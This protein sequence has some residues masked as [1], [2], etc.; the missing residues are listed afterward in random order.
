MPRNLDIALLRAFV[1]VAEA[2]GMTRAATLLNLTQG[3]VSQQVKRLEG[4]FDTTLFERD[5]AGLRLTPRGE[6]LLPQARR[7]LEANDALWTQMT[8]PEVE[9]EVRVGVPHDIVTPYMPPILRAFDREWPRVQV[10]IIADTSP[11]LLEKLAAG[12]IDLTLTTERRP[13]EEAEVLAVEPLVW[14]G[15]PG[16]LAHAR[17]PLPL[18]LGDE[19]C[20]FRRSVLEALADAGLD[21]RM[22]CAMH[23]METLIAIAAADLG[24]TPLLRVAVPP[25]LA[26]L[27]EDCGLPPLPPFAIALYAPRGRG[28]P[29]DML[30]DHIRRAFAAR[31]AAPQGAPSAA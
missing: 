28:T 15:P 7:L 14:A 13:A 16:G 6:R 1:T 12:D 19:T 18:A 25:T 31:A 23:N 30:A 29:T 11:H 8:A 21:W 10:A 9:G 20:A 26:V 3:A 5:R 22:V 27:P 24:V 2:G 17:R 4:L